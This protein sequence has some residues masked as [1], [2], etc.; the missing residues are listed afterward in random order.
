MQKPKFNYKLKRNNLIGEKLPQRLN[1]RRFQKNWKMQ[2][3][4]D[5]RRLIPIVC[6]LCTPEK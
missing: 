4:D 3:A 5:E 2:F 6:H 1:Q